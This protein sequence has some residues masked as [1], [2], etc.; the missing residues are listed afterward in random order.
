MDDINQP[1]R[2]VGTF[3]D[4]KNALDVI[5]HDV[6]V[7]KLDRYVNTGLDKELFI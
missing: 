5:N 4:L 7:N 6:L 3:K 2:T 1:S